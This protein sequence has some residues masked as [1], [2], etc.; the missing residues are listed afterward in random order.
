[1]DYSKIFYVV[2]AVLFILGL[3]KLSHP[4]TARNGNMIS[5]V[6]MLIAIVATLL[7]Y[8]SLDFTLILI[9]MLIG[10]LIGG[11]FAVKV[12]MTQMPQ[13]V[14]IFNGF[15]GAASALVAGA[16]F[17]TNMDKLKTGEMINGLDPTFY[18]VVVILSIF[19]G[20][21]TFTGSFIAFGKLQGFISG[22][23]IIFP[24]QQI[25]NALFAISLIS[26]TV[27]LSM[28]G[29]DLVNFFYAIVFNYLDILTFQKC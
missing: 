29:N 13:M 12:E 23:P 4:K 8:N 18:L 2:S 28:G 7:S 20:T 11:I 1:M 15:G 3:K 27:Y 10:G 14:A 24:G 25:L 5:S 21:L 26:I 6:G 9:G 17:I 16:D 19:V 22:Q